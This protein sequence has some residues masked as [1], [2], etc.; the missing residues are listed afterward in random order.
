MQAGLGL[1]SGPLWIMVVI[2]FGASLQLIFSLP[3]DS[4]L[5]VQK[6]VKRIPMINW[7]CSWSRFI[8][9]WAG[10]RPHLR[11]WPNDFLDEHRKSEAWQLGPILDR[12]SWLN[13]QLGPDKFQERPDKA[14]HFQ[15][16]LGLSSVW[17]CAFIVGPGMDIPQ[18]GSTWTMK[19]PKRSPTCNV[20]ISLFSHIYHLDISVNNIFKNKK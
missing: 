3:L 2:F 15:P 20:L 5:S 7:G 18:P 14:R 9:L 12:S 10:F 13:G 6:T 4:L 8:L 16:V 11:F 1:D 17:T 19:T